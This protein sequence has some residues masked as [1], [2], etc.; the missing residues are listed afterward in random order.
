MQRRKLIYQAKPLLA[1]LILLFLVGCGTQIPSGH[2]GV[3]YFKFG[4]GTEMG[5]IYDEGFNWHFPWNKIYVYKVQLEE[6]KEDLPLLI[7]HFLEQH[8]PHASRTALPPRVFQTLLNHDWPGNIR[9]LQ[10]VLQRYLTVNRLEFPGSRGSAYTPN[11]E[12]CP[13][14]ETAI[15]SQKLQEAVDAFEKQFLRRMLEQHHWHKVQTAQ[16]LDI[17]R[18]TLYRKMKQ[19]DLL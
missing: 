12:N 4:D 3:K 11:H 6:R 7:E 9:E 2:R 18:K 5:K 19:F 14:F 10:N 8:R 1:F 13:I 16:A 15:E 17:G